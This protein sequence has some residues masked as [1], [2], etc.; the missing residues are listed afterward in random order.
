MLTANQLRQAASQARRD[1]AHIETDVLL[2]YLLEMFV[3][4][5]LTNDLAF[6]AGTMLRK[7]VFGPQGRLSTDLDFTQRSDRDF[8]DIILE[9]LEALEHE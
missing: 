4:R 7:M 6:K 5:G 3:E 8:D 1:I 9:L 2:T